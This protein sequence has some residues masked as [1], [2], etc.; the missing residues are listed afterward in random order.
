MSEEGNICKFCGKKFQ[1][2]STLSVH[3]CE[4]KRRHQQEKEVGVQLGF[5]AFLRFFELTQATSKLKTYEDFSKNP[6]Y[7]AFVKFGRYLV[8]IKAINTSNYID[9]LIKNNKKIDHWAR[10]SLYQE[11]LLNYIKKEAV[12]DALERSLKTMQEYADSKS[13][14][15]DRFFDYFRIGSTS[16]IIQQI[17][18]GR[19]SPWVVF[20]STSGVELL[21]KLNEAEI[22]IILPYIDP[23]YWQKRFKEYSLDT[24]WVK[25]ILKKAG[26]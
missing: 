13:G 16:Y 23:D 26:L 19:I 5:K 6:F 2:L 14:L 20:N 7:L 12:Q 11:W 24:D 9:W 3:L 22:N 10:D 1:K 8:D 18:F 17:E 25:D 21:E 4:A 15:E